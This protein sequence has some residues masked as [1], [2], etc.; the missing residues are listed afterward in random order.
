MSHNSKEGVYL[1][2]QNGRKSKTKIVSKYMI[3]ITKLSNKNT[4]GISPANIK[5]NK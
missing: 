5:R 3:K 1:K 2:I 4:T